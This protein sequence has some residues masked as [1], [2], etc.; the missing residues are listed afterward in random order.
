M[1]CLDFPVRD[2]GPFDCF[3]LD[4]NDGW[5]LLTAAEVVQ[6]VLSNKLV[7]TSLALLGAAAVFGPVLRIRHDWKESRFREREVVAQERS[8][9]ALVR[10]ADSLERGRRDP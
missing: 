3:E 4:G 9:V 10:V 7:Q 1:G 6:V 5:S 8:S 2:G